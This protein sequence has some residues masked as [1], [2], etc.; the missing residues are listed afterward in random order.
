MAAVAVPTG[1]LVAVD[2]YPSQRAED[3]LYTP[4]IARTRQTLGQ[5]GLL[6]CGDGKMAALATRAALEAVGDY[7]LVPLP[8]GK[9]AE[10]TVTAWHTAGT[11]GTHPLLLVVRG[12]GDAAEVLGGGYERRRM[13]EAEQGGQRVVWEERL[14]VIRSRDLLARESGH[15]EDRVKNAEAALTRFALPPKRGRRQYRD[16]A[17]LAAAITQKLDAL[18]V[19]G[20]LDVILAEETGGRQSRWIVTEVTRNAVALAAARDTLGWRVL[21]TN[22]PPTR[23]SLAEGMITQRGGWQIE[24]QFH[25]LHDHPLG[26]TPLQVSRDDQ[27]CGLVRLLTLGLRVLALLAGLVRQGLERD[28][29]E[30]AGLYPGQPTRLTDHPTAVRLLRAIA[31]SEMTLIHGEVAGHHVQFLTPVSPVLHTV[32]AYC[33]LQTTID[34]RLAE[35]P[36]ARQASSQKG[37]DELRE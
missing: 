30:M 32:L 2:V 37:G 20:L 18:Q 8:L 27:W 34:T 4:L 3:G 33:Q 12:T 21:A 26:I 25:Q 7:Y 23:L 13:Q 16:R 1:V 28:G 36:L 35:N 6:Y 31:A 11:D 22:A 24:Q 5:T 9:E 19:T 17:S 29:L 14:L 15:L 10:A